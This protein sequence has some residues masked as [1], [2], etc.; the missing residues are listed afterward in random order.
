MNMRYVAFIGT[1]IGMIGFNNL[2]AVTAFISPK[3]TFQQ[4]IVNT[5]KNVFGADRLYQKPLDT[6]YLSD[7]RNIVNELEAFV[8]RYSFNDTDTKLIKLYR[9]I[10]RANNELIKAINDTYNLLFRSKKTRGNTTPTLNSARKVFA[11]LEARTMAAQ[12]TLKALDYEAKETGL[13]KVREALVILALCV[14][15]AATKASK[16]IEKEIDLR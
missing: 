14:Q 2:N 12:E 16:D 6:T 7:W 11:N 9:D 10:K 1:M 4:N 3:N 13:I 8:Q 5:Y 15:I